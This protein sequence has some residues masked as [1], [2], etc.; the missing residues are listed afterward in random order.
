MPFMLGEAFLPATLTKPPLTDREFA[1][2]CARRHP[3]A[4]RGSRFSSAACEAVLIGGFNPFKSIA[5]NLIR[6]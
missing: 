4:A 2:L 1:D 6:G 3:G 5:F